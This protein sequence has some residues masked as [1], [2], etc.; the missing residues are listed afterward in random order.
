MSD[1]ITQPL[2]QPAPV[3]AQK[4]IVLCLTL[5]KSQSQPPAVRALA[6]AVRE[7]ARCL[8]LVVSSVASSEQDTAA[9]LSAISEQFAEI[10]A[11]AQEPA[12]AEPESAP[13]AQQAPAAAP[14]ATNKPRS[15]KG[16]SSDRT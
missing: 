10:L 14:A 7:L 1:I 6:G 2:P 8:Q 5:E 15:R 3:D 13:A 4:V 16:A 12:H 9:H 11:A